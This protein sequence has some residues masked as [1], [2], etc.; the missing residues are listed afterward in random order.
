MSEIDIRNK[1]KIV[2]SE[3][4]DKEKNIEI[5]E[6]NI[7]QLSVEKKSFNNIY[8]ETLSEEYYSSFIEASTSNFISSS[9]G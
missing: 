3:Y 9:F 6:N 5:I 7:Y 2:L 8:F 4:L 1:G